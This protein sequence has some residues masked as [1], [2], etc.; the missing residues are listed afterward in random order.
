MW[1]RKVA[2]KEYKIDYLALKCYFLIHALPET[3]TFTRYKSAS[4]LSGFQSL[5]CKTISRIGK[6]TYNVIRITSETG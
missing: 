2:Y 3:D 4:L 1:L 5:Q 6:G